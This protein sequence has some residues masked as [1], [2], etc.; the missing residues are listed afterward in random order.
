MEYRA[1]AMKE[2]EHE[3]SP[4]QRRIR[5]DAILKWLRDNPDS[6]YDEISDAFDYKQN[7]SNTYVNEAEENGE[8][9]RSNN[10]KPYTWRVADCTDLAEKLVPVHVPSSLYWALEAARMAKGFKEIHE[11]L[12]YWWEHW[13]ATQDSEKKVTLHEAATFARKLQNLDF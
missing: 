2:D 12:R 8:V 5:I 11:V 1:F 4:A 3:Q 13:T 10:K 9:V 7:W 6:T